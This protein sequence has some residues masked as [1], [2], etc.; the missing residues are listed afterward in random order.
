MASYKLIKTLRLL[1]CSYQHLLW[2]TKLLKDSSY[3]YVL[4]LDY[5]ISQN[6]T[7]IH[8]VVKSYFWASRLISH[9]HCL[10]RSVALYQCL[11]ARGYDVQHKF[12]VHK[13]NKQFNAHAWVEYQGKP[14]NEH[15]Q[16]RQRFRV[17]ERE[18]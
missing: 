2:V 13:T 6:N 1:P 4:S 12:G 7:S 9:N 18:D 3:E 10:A 5:S 14:L 16:L 8:N 17:L 11:T 15:P